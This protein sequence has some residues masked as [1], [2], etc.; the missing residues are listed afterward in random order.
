MSHI[1]LLN[2]LENIDFRGT[3]CK[4]MESYLTDRRR[5]T[6]V[7]Y[8]FSDT[9]IVQCGVP[10]GT[11]LGPLLFNIYLNDLFKVQTGGTVLSLSDDTAIFYWDKDWPTLKKICK[12]IYTKLPLLL[13]I[14]YFFFFLCPPC[15]CHNFFCRVKY[16]QNKIKYF[17]VRKISFHY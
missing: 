6:N 12:V 11:T 10:Q 2:I 17:F 14:F 13:S 15:I 16:I 3:P 5:C 7:S 4:L 9:K 1:Q 8:T